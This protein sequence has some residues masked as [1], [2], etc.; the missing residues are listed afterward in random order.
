ME[1]LPTSTTRI[2]NAPGLVQ[3]LIVRTLSP[4]N[5]SVLAPCG[6][7]SH[8]AAIPIA[9]ETNNLSPSR[10]NSS[11]LSY[12]PSRHDKY[13]SLKR[14]A[15]KDMQNGSLTNLAM[16][17]FGLLHGGNTY[18]HPKM[19]NPSACLLTM[20]AT[21]IVELLLDLPMCAHQALIVS[22][23][24]FQLLTLPICL[25]SKLSDYLLKLF[26]PPTQHNTEFLLQ[27]DCLTFLLTRLCC[28]Q[29]IDIR[30][31]LSSVALSD[32]LQLL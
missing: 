8:N 14:S 4:G 20:L 7:S 15:A 30:R 13:T 26:L 16:A 11:L 12:S 29:S 27:S 24:F 19:S 6:C 22:V 2:A 10:I 9:V 31:L 3:L 18:S 1:L 32:S 5:G 17:F 23:H 21:V 25:L 28:Q